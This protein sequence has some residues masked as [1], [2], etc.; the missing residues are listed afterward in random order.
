[1]KDK[2]FLKQVGKKIAR[3]RKEQKMTQ[4][5]LSDLCEME[6][7]ALARLEAGGANITALT[8]LKIARALEVPAKKFLDFDY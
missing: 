2:E 1:M 4:V 8:L 3:Y 5:Q 7:S 6:Q